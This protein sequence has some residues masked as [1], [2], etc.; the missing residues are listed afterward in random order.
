MPM[1]RNLKKKTDKKNIHQKEQLKFIESQIT[2]I[3]N[4]AEDSQS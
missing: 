3:G 1:H 2:K 4:L